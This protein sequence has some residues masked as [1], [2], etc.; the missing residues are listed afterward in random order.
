MV[1]E[2]PGFSP[3][4]ARKTR[5]V[6][7]SQP[8]IM[9]SNPDL[10]IKLENS[11]YLSLRMNSKIRLGESPMDKI[12]RETRTKKQISRHREYA[13]QPALYRTVRTWRADS[14]AAAADRRP[15]CWPSP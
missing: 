8:R 1:I 13:A 12:S 4:G 6:S 5:S 15:P 11:S 9:R 14:P 3:K 2:A 7:K 10:L